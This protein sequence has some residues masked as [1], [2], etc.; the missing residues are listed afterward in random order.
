MCLKWGKSNI[1]K[2]NDKLTFRAAFK[3]MVGKKIGTG[4]GRK[5][6]NLPGLTVLPS[7]WQRNPT[8]EDGVEV[9]R[10]VEQRTNP[11]N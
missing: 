7:D 6:Q 8:T 11:D 4:L 2:N 3:D 9:L 1:D 5:Q 10:Q